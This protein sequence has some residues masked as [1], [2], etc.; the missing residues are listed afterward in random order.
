[1]GGGVV[2]VI[3]KIL[4]IK[5]LKKAIRTTKPEDYAK[6]KTR[7]KNKKKKQTKKTKKQQQKK[8]KKKQTPKNKIF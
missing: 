3:F 7:K 8:P 2:G 4:I 1:G 6:R 5:I